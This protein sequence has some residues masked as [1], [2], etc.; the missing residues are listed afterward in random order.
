MNPTTTID[1][2]LYEIVSTKTITELQQTHPNL[3][4]SLSDRGWAGEA[5]LRRPRGRKIYP[6]YYTAD[7][8]FV[9]WSS[10]GF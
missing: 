10:R 7:G 8:R 4:F 5:V 6:A 9:R 2:I 3:A 1:G